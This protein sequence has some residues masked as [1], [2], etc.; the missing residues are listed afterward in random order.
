MGFAFGRSGYPR[1]NAELA[2][3]Y[4]AAFTAIYDNNFTTGNLAPE[5]GAG[6]PVF[7]RASAANY[8]DS[9][10]VL[11]SAATD[12]AR[13]D[14][15]YIT[16]FTNRG[17][18]LE[19]S[20]NSRIINNRD[21][22]NA[23]WTKTNGT[24]AKDQTG[25][26]NVAN[27]ASS[28]LATANAATVQRI[29][30]TSSNVFSVY[31][32]WIVTT[33]TIEITVDG[34]TWTDITSQ[35]HAT[36]WRRVFVANASAAQFQCGIRL[37]ANTAKI[38]VDFAQGENAVGYPSSPVATAA[39]T[40]TRSP[41]LPTL[42]L[43]SIT[44]LST[45]DFTVAL[46]WMA[47]HAGDITLAREVINIDDGSTSNRLFVRREATTANIGFR[48][49]NAG[50]GQATILSGVVE[51]ELAISRAV[52]SA[53][54]NRFTLAA[55]VGG[56]RPADEA[57]TMPTVTTLRLGH[58]FGGTTNLFGWLRRIRFWNGAL[59][60]AYAKLIAEGLA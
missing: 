28:F 47:G 35:M 56:I 26:D 49:V 8:F 51:P 22:S 52:A 30:A 11:Q 4:A 41:D 24:A 57:G 20:R 13:F 60:S 19:G 55:S 16:P 33:G 46:E 39:A 2:A 9:S 21:L 31:L 15:D 59:P 12:V 5:I 6:T 10:G 43:S 34:I 14:Y 32:K 54:A 48:V 17:L 18:L 38:A 37:S 27:S 58:I 7:T 40:V 25:I 36:Q 1:S 42:A 29:T 45:T 3:L 23:S 53:R 44:G 50:Q